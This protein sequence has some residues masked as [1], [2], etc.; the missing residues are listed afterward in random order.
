MQIF[1]P[2]VYGVASIVQPRQLSTPN[3]FVHVP[4][5]VLGFLFVLLCI[6]VDIRE[7]GSTFLVPL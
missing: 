2:Y 6:L 5:K 3:I 4:H 7:A 1:C